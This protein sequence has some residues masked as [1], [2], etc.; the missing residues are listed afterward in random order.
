MGSHCIDEPAKFKNAPISLQVVGKT[1]EE[2]AL[3]GMTEIVD[4][5]VRDLRRVEGSKL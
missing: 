3:I 4:A 5:A 2:E 1:L